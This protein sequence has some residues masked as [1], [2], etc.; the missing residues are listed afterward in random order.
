MKKLK[1]RKIY[2][3]L[4]VNINRSKEA[5]RVCEEIARFV[6]NNKVLTKNLRS[7]RHSIGDIVGRF[8]VHERAL[9]KF[10]DIRSDFG[11]NRKFE[12]HKRKDICGILI[13]NFQRAKE[14]T[15][16]LEEFSK[17]LDENISKD[18]KILRF[19]LYSLEKRLIG[20]TQSLCNNRYKKEEN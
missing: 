5:L 2:R 6:L 15:R 12:N 20:K 13:A 14:A 18:F 17:A 1:E 10:R 9:I 16:V 8:P 11:R 19:K 3:I 7:I 4:D